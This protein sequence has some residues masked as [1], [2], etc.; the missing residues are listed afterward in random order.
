[1]VQDRLGPPLASQHSQAQGPGDVGGVVMNGSN[2]SGGNAS[3]SQTMLTGPL[4]STQHLSRRPSCAAVAVRAAMHEQ[5]IGGVFA[6]SKQTRPGRGGVA[7]RTSMSSAGGQGTVYSAGTSQISDDDRSSYAGS[8]AE[9]ASVAGS[10]ASRRH[11]RRRKKRREAVP[12]PFKA[13]PALWAD[14]YLVICFVVV[15]SIVSAIEFR[16]VQL[17][18]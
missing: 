6:M 12:D 1:M 8:E 16:A 14:H 17:G 9:T 13:W 7:R 5:G 10:T 18:L 11:R 2:A 4:D 15:S 3:S